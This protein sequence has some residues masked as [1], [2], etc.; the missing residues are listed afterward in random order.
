MKKLKNILKIALVLPLFFSAFISCEK[1]EDFKDLLNQTTTSQ[2]NTVF[3]ET[4]DTSL[5]PHETGAG[6]NYENTV[7]VGI[8]NPVN[9]DVTVTFKV[10][11]TDGTAVEGVDY[12]IMDATILA[13]EKIA[14]T[15]VVFL[16]EG[17]YTVS[18]D[19]VSDT[20]L[21]IS[22]N[23]LLFRVRPPFIKATWDDSYY[24]YD[25]YLVTG[26]QDFNGTVIASSTGIT[27]L[28][29]IFPYPQEAGTTTLFIQDYWGDNAS[30]PVTLEVYDGTT[31]HTYNVIMDMSKWVLKIET[32]IDSDGNYTFVFTEL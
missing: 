30:T 12:T 28:E 5:K 23:K 27:N 20:S 6:P 31:T 13:G 8:N 1:E 14:E 16:T 19:T 25:L 3:I 10:N 17:L 2:E 32:S 26:D 22:P 15:T 21:K 9:N 29:E 24:D 18:I 7:K 4:D 11:N